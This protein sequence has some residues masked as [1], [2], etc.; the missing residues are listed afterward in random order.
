MHGHG[1]FYHQLGSDLA[2]EVQG[3]D[4]GDQ[5]VGID[6]FIFTVCRVIDTNVTLISP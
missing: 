5:A 3:G 2:E 4:A 1:V 6:T